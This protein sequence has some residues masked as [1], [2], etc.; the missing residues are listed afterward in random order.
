[1][2]SYEK[3]TPSPSREASLSISYIGDNKNILN[4]EDKGIITSYIICQKYH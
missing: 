4:I 3:R 2:V 1:M